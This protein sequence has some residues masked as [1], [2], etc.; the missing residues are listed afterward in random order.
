MAARSATTLQRHI[1]GWLCRLR[2]RRFRWAAVT[3]QCA[4]RRWAALRRFRFLRERSASG[5][6]PVG[7]L[8]AGLERK[9]LQ[10]QRA[11]D[12]RVRGC[13]VLWGLMGSYGVRRGEKMGGLGVLG[14]FLGSLFG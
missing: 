7:N 9:V 3:L 11:V 5:A 14:A 10:L 12:C 1:R 2:Y 8:S 13:G 4:F 6:P